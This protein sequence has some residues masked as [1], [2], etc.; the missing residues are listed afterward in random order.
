MKKARLYQ[1][2]K[3]AMQSG[4]G[5][6][7]HWVLEFAPEGEGVIDPLMGW[8]GSTDMQQQVVLQFE[9]QEAALHYAKAHHIEVELV[10]TA[11]RRIRPK[12]YAEN[13]N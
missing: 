7:K 12:S 11:T 8:N 3:N 4:V 10:E 5:K 2:T 13:F 1:P 6:T 9:T